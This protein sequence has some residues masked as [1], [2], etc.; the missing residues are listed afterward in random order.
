VDR[1]TLR[2]V[3]AY[4]R[5]GAEPSERETTAAFEIALDAEV[6]LRRAAQTDDLRDT[7]DYA[8]LH[9]RIVRIVATTSYALLE[10]LAEDVL[11]AIFE[12]ARIAS[13]EVTI[14]KP[15]RLDGATPAVTLRRSNPR[16]QS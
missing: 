2:D 3:Y 4:G 10:R 7:V 16:F 8:A 11:A 1:I 9:E 6:D 5:H 12:D 14:G 15:G 13:A